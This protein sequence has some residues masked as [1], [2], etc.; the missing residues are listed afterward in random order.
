MAAQSAAHKRWMAAHKR[1]MAA[2]EAPGQMTD[3]WW[4]QRMEARFDAFERRI[5][6]KFAAVLLPC[7]GL[8]YA[9]MRF[10]P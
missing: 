6:I 1:Q 5:T 3:D 7:L 10:I 2:L 4:I 8:F 9:A